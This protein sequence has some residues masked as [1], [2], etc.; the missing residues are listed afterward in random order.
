MKKTTIEIIKNEIK[1]N[2]E[3]MHYSLWISKDFP[4]SIDREIEMDKIYLKLIENTE[5]LNKLYN[6]ILT[7][8]T[9]CKTLKTKYNSPT[10]M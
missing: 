3:Y 7:N 6:Y 5:K 9:K 2:G 10:R 4:P 1:I 8:I